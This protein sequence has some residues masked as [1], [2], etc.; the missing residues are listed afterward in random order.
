M[1]A[2]SQAGRHRCEESAMK[3]QLYG[4]GITAAIVFTLLMPNMAQAACFKDVFVFDASWCPSCRKVKA[5]L[6][7]YGVPYQTI[8]VTGNRS[9]QAFMAERFNTTM[10]PVTVIDNSFVI[11]FNESRIKQLLCIY[12]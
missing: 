10:I 11:G 12:D 6:S 5:M 3:R 9:A 8:E 2:I 4:L 7:E 1:T